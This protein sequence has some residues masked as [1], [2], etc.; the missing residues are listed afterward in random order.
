LALGV[1]IYHNAMDTGQFDKSQTVFTQQI[2]SKYQTVVFMGEM[3]INK[4]I[5]LKATRIYPTE[6]NNPLG[7]YSSF[8][9]GYKF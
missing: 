4:L 8:Q 2:P 3:Q 5:S 6:A 7:T 9:L 1:G